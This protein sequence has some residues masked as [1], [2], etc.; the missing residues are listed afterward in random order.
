MNCDNLIWPVTLM[1]ADFTDQEQYHN[2]LQEAY[3]AKW[4][5]RWAAPKHP[6]SILWHCACT[7]SL[8]LLQSCTCCSTRPACRMLGGCSHNASHFGVTSP[9]TSS[10][11]GADRLRHSAG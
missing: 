8:S 2:Q 3:L 5:C 11:R 1:L 6:R 9:T 7:T 4:L 10:P